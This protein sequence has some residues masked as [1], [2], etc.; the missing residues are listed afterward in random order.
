MKRTPFIALSACAALA[1][2]E[3]DFTPYNELEGLRVLAVRAE[4]PELAQDESTVLDAL[5]FHDAT[6]TP[7]LQWSLCPWPS[8]PDTGFPC[9]IDR[10]LWLRAWGEAGLAGDA[11]SLALGTSDTA[12]LTFP[13][14]RAQARKLCEMLTVALENSAT[15]PPDCTRSYPWTVRLSTRLGSERVETVKDVV[16]LLDE[17]LVP[18]QNPTL[19]ALRV[20]TGEDSKVLD[21]TVTTELAAGVDHDL[22]VDVGRGSA[23]TYLPMPA[24]GQPQPAATEESLT[25]TWFVDQGSTDRVR[26]TYKKGV[27]TMKR[28]TENVWEAPNEATSARTFVVVRDHRGGVDFIG[29]PVLL[30]K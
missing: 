9:P 13:G 7:E 10:A 6:Q 23:E 8:D 11:P 15:L 22:K 28:A 1:G 18:N 3:P 5:L 27:E 30:T 24:L 20:V 2:C 25:F 17:S 16:L 12:E 21:P 14:T 29:A 26:S 19:T 4:P